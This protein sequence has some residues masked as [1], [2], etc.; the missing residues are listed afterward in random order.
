MLKIDD[1]LVEGFV[2]FDEILMRLRGNFGSSLGLFWCWFVVG[3]GFWIIVCT[4]VTLIVSIVCLFIEVGGVLLI[5]SSWWLNFLL[6]FIIKLIWVSG[7]LFLFFEH[8]LIIHLLNFTHFH[9]IVLLFLTLRPFGPL[10]LMFFTFIIF[11]RNRFRLC[12]FLKRLLD[13]PWFILT[14]FLISSTIFS[15]Y[16]R[17]VE[18]K[19]VT[20]CRLLLSLI[21]VF[22][23]KVL[24]VF[25]SCYVIFVK[26]HLANR[27]RTTFFELFYLCLVHVFLCWSLSRWLL[28]LWREIALYF[29]LVLFFT[30]GFLLFSFLFIFG[31][32]WLLFIWLSKKEI[33]HFIKRWLTAF[34]YVL[35]KHIKLNQSF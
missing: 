13:W 21:I 18:I 28:V 19:I 4:G 24:I 31:W 22:W 15:I 5:W 17:L 3:W 11:N 14:F 34:S 26:F 7:C 20:T 35:N 10:F 23:S 12:C 6:R 32:F 27:L 30:F 2:L 33:R 8:F 29:F 1:S 9:I 16:L 25:A